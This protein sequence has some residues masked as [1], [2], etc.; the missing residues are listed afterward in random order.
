MNNITHFLKVAT[1][2]SKCHRCRSFHEIVRALDASEMSSELK[3]L[4]A[5][6]QTALVEI[7]YNNMGCDPC[8]SSQTALAANQHVCELQKKGG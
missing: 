1:S 3:P 2:F 6:A 5:A 4:L 8:W 7:E